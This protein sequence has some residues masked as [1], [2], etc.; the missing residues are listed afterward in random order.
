MRLQK[1]LTETGQ[2]LLTAGSLLLTE[3]DEKLCAM[4]RQVGCEL[5]LKQIRQ[6][7]YDRLCMPQSGWYLPPYE[8]VFKKRYRVDN[9]WHFPAA[10]YDQAVQV[11]SIYARYAF[12]HEQLCVHPL[13]R[14]VYPGDHLGFM[15]V[16]AGSLLQH[17]LED[18][19]WERL[20]PDLY[21]FA[22][23]HL[24]DWLED[25]CDLL[26]VG[27]DSGYLTAVADALREAMTSLDGVLVIDAPDSAAYSQSRTIGS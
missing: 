19:D 26:P 18:E 8:Q 3:P 16:F 21:G 7:F 4:L 15:L 23:A 1:Q 22:Q 12:R 14:G 2:L 10:H 27:D 25:F 24:N 6:R 17:P 11:E 13:L 5:S 20:R 9:I